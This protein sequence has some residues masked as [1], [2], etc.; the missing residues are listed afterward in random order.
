MCQPHPT[1]LSDATPVLHAPLYYNS[2]V[3]YCLSPTL[4][5]APPSLPPLSFHLPP[6]LLSS[7][8]P[9]FLFTTYLSSSPACLSS[10][11]YTPHSSHPTPPSFPSPT[12]SPSICPPLSP[13]PPPFT[14]CIGKVAPKEL[15]I[16]WDHNEF[17]CQHAGC[18]K[19]FRKQSLLQSH[20]KHYHNVLQ[21]PPMRRGRLPTGA[22]VGDVVDIAKFQKD[23]DF[24]SIV[25]LRIMHNCVLSCLHC[26]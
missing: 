26:V 20:M 8:L 17:K 6:T 25:F 3:V 13:P 22:G 21:M 11:P 5:L 15:V 12:L 19:S 4:S 23:S 9:S 7:P 10:L 14:C 1:S 24:Q 16:L 18:A 2:S